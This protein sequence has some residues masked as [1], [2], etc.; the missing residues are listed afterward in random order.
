MFSE[1][2]IDLIAVSI[3]NSARNRAKCRE[4]GRYLT[5]KKFFLVGR[6]AKMPMKSLFFRGLHIEGGSVRGKSGEGLRQGVGVWCEESGRCCNKPGE[7]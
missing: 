3:H 6:M 2:S 4:K 5:L 1:V 7:F